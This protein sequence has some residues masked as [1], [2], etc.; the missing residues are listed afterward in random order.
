[1]KKLLRLLPILLLMTLTACQQQTQDTALD[2]VPP[3][4]EETAED[5]FIA[6]SEGEEVAHNAQ[7]SYEE[8]M[9]NVPSDANMMPIYPDTFCGAYCEENQIILHMVITADDAE[10]LAYYQSFFSNPDIVTYDTAAYSYNAL[11]A[12]MYLIVENSSNWHSIGVDQMENYVDVSASD[13]EAMQADLQAIFGDVWDMDTLPVCV[14][15][16]TVVTTS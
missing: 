6:P 9:S 5:F 16:G 15:Q 8:F 10:T 7:M 3:V 12:M 2:V 14:E 4:E 1:M 13:V 11:E